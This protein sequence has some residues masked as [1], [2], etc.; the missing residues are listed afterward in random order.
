MDLTRNEELGPFSNIV[1]KLENDLSNTMSDL[2][3]QVDSDLTVY[4]GETEH[5]V[6]FLKS[7]SLIIVNKVMN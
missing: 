1:F 5:V 6:Q 4:R 3:R 7:G 2:S